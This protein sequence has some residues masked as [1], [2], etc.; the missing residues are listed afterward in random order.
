MEE[1]K[2]EDQSCLICLR[3]Y[4]ED[5]YISGAIIKKCSN[6]GAKVWLSPASQNKKFDK[7]LC[8]ECWELSF[9]RKKDEISYMKESLEEFNDWHKSRLGYK[10]NEDDVIIEIEKIIGA[11]IKLSK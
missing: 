2:E 9:D 10:M 5:P 8:S 3:S 4:G 1:Q 6:C 7:I 11:K